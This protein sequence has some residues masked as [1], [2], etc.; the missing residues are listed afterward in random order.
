MGEASKTVVWRWKGTPAEIGR[1]ASLVAEQTGPTQPFGAEV[2]DPLG[3]TS[4]S[5]PAELSAGLQGHDKFS[6]LVIVGGFEGGPCRVVVYF[7]AS[8]VA[9]AGAT[10]VAEGTDP[11]A[12][13]RAHLAVS[14][15]VKAGAREP[16][17]VEPSTVEAWAGFFTIGFTPLGL[18]FLYLG[19]EQP[20]YEL[21]LFGMIAMAV[22]TIATWLWIG[23]DSLIP[24]VEVLHPGQSPRI[25]TFAWWFGGIAV[26]L[27]LAA[28]LGLS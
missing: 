9:N 11:A 6:A 17:D 16:K 13:Q 15:A 18:L 8:G 28:A 22:A 26:S 12:V 25:V 23:Y 4:F 20:S 7:A 3:R 27:F 24:Q 5:S 10:V 1:I 21:T 14:T 2:V 19:F